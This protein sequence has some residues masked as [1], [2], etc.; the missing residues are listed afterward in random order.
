MPTLDR[1]AT[2]N[3]LLQIHYRSLTMYLASARPWVAP[4]YF[5][6]G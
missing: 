1:V 6:P 5:F 3:R 4:E 2:L